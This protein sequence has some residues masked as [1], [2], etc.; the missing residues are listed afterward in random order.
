MGLPLF[1]LLSLIKSNT[2]RPHAREIR[3]NDLSHFLPDTN[4]SASGLTVIINFD[5]S[6]QIE[7][8]D[9]L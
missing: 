2:E 8:D 9:R 5:N 7:I 3:D 4:T 6:S 1:M